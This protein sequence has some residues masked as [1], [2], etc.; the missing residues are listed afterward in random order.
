MTYCE[1]GRMQYTLPLN[2]APSYSIHDF[3]FSNC[4]RELK[5]ILDNM[6][7]RWGYAPYPEIILLTGTKGS[8]R[9]HFGHI[10]KATNPQVIIL[11]DIDGCNEKE[12]LHQFNVCHENRQNALFICE[13]YKHF[14]LPDLKSRLSSVRIAHIGDPDDI[15]I[16]F[17]LMKSLTERSIKTS[18]DVI[19]YLLVRI[20]RSFRAISNTIAL[21]DKASMEQKRN[22]TVSFLASLKLDELC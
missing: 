2:K 5:E 6:D 18:E 21:I 4:N 3:I 8:G 20:P 22:I 12:L 11:D 14:K 9:T 1:R 15:M 13:D 7:N 17:L 16:R 10:I 19:K